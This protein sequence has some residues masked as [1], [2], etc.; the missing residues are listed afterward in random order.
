MPSVKASIEFLARLDKYRAEKPYVILLG[1][2]EDSDEDI[3][4]SN[5]EFDVVSQIDIRDMREHAELRFEQCAFEFVAHHQSKVTEFQTPADVA[6]YAAE[7]RSLLMNR[8]D[9]VQVCTYEVKLRQNIFF[10][11]QVYDVNDSLVIEGP[12]IG[13]H[14]GQRNDCTHK[15]KR[16]IAELLHRCHH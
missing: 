16:V 4:T 8:F 15:D 10:D 1:E 7:T 3:P 9:A 2:D 14:N 13:A 11:R 12:A 5:L 6:A